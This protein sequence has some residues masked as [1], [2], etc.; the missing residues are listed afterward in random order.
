MTGAIAEILSDCKPSVYLYG[1]TTLD[2]F[3]Y[4]WSDIDILVLTQKVISDEQANELV[5]LRQ[6]MAEEYQNNQYFRSFEGGMLSVSGF[7]D[8][9]PDRVVYWGTSGQRITDFYVFDSFSMAEL[10]ENGILLFGDDVRGDFK[11]PAY[12]SFH[13]D[14]EKHYN[15]IR[16]YAQITDR[17]LYSFG[18]LLDIARCIYT[19]R[20]GKIIA[21]T[22]AGEWSL[23]NAICP[24]PTE[25]KKALSVRKNPTEYLKDTVT[26][27]YAETLGPAIQK[28]ADV[29]EKE[30]NK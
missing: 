6:K 7:M 13:L 9:T 18:W 30:L 21:K 14:V 10:L 26:F 3:K 25:L 12:E 16:R 4:G 27:D 8:R 19:L 17:S 5:F 23:E 29:L 2:D 15:A 22:K 1:S 20:T 11:Y 28:F 24:V